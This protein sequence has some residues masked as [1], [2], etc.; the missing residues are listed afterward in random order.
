MPPP[1]DATSIQ[2]AFFARA[3]LYTVPIHPELPIDE[4]QAESG[5][6]FYRFALDG[7]RV[8]WAEKWLAERKPLA[9]EVRLP[10]GLAAGAH[11]FA[12]SPSGAATRE[13]SL[14]DLRGYVDYLRVEVSADG[15]P[16][17]GE[18]VTR[19][20][21]LRHDYE[22]WDNGQLKRWRFQGADNQGEKLFDRSG[23]PLN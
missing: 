2:A 8:L 22:Y 6:S 23:K 5:R 1:A 9:T 4:A 16:L 19:Q 10:A 13:L 3:N 11:F 17:L 15:H 7:G 21:V 18:R 14:V 12:L 20:R